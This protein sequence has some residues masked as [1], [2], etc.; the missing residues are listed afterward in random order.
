VQNGFVE[1]EALHLRTESSIKAHAKQDNKE[2]NKLSSQMIEL[3]HQ[4]GDQSDRVLGAQIG[5]RMAIEIS[6]DQNLAEHNKT[7]EEMNRLREQAERQVEVL[8]EEIRQLKIELE[9]SVK[10]IVTSLGTASKKEG[11]KL[12]DTSNAKFNLWVAKELILE[13][14]KVS[15]SLRCSVCF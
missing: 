9:A 14:L 13:N 11:Q 4:S 5:I 15:L 10:A 6:G 7:R 8:T 2:H 3:S 12:K 1:L